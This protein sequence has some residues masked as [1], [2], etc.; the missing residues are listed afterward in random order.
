M[1]DTFRSA[2]ITAFHDACLGRPGWPADES[3][4]LD[5]VPAG[6]LADAWGWVRV[7]HRFNCSLWDEEDL[8]R[9]TQAA[10]AEIAANKRAIDRFNQARND[11]MERIDDTLLRATADWPRAADARASSETAGA[12]IDRM[13]ILALKIHHMGLQT[14]RTDVDDAHRAATR[15]KLAQ[16]RAQRADLAGCFDR[17]LAEIAAGTGYFRIYRQ[18]KMYNDPT[19]N[20][21]LVAERRARAGG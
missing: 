1:L 20:P 8:A 5:L 19:M 16:L 11:A 6:P 4:A 15:D 14:T 21:V 13:S 12:M 17:L 2:A 18:F 10:D 9:R 7:N 3:A